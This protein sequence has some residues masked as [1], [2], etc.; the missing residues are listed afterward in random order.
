MGNVK[1]RKDKLKHFVRL[2]KME[3][4]AGEWGKDIESENGRE[5]MRKKMWKQKANERDRTKITKY[6]TILNEMN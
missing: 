5:R 2:D 1:N 3:E 4:K 6:R